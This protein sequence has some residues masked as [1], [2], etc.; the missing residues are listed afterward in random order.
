MGV[1][2]YLDWGKMMS[3]LRLTDREWGKFKIGDIFEIE[4]C[5]CSKVSSLQEG[6]VSYVGATN[7]NNGVL[8]F[9]EN[10]STLISKG[11]CI[12]F[13]CD[14]EG[15]I[16]YSIYKHEDFIGSTTVK[17]GRN[18]YLNKYTGLFIVTSS[19]MTRGRYNFG[20][21]RNEVNLKREI[22]ML[23]VNTDGQPDWQFMEDFIRQIEQ[24]KIQTV[25]KYYNSLNNNKIA[26]GG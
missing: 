26:R 3:E 19:N 23:P 15:S 22:I 20:Y 14:G 10:K 12:A 11:N 1:G 4:K 18:Q 25:L 9:V 8:S 13:I 5:K 6:N 2:I 21:K 24:N 16:G 17:I 7:R